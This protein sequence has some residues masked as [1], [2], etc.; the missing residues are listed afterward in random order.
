VL[1]NLSS[2]A[3]KFTAAGRVRLAVEALPGG[4]DR[5]RL[6]LSVTD[7]GSGID[8]GLRA[9]LF[10]PFVQGDTSAARRA[11][12][13]GLGLAI[14]R[15]IVDRMGGRI[16]VDSALGV[17]SRFTVE[18]ALPVAAEA[19][20]AT[21][22][23]APSGVEGSPRVLLVEDH[24]LSQEILTEMLEELGCEVTIAGTGVEAM[25]LA[26]AAAYDLILM[27]LQ[28]P[29]V[30][31]LTATRLIRLLPACRHTPIVALSANVFQE[32]RVRALEAGMNEHVAKP[33]TALDLAAVLK[34]WVP[35]A[36][37]G[38]AAR[39]TAADALLGQLR[40]SVADD[41]TRLR[42]RLADGDRAQAADI[43]HGA[44]GA[45]AL[46]GAAG[47]G[48][49]LAALERQLRRA[50]PDADAAVAADDQARLAAVALA[51]EALTGSLAQP[52]V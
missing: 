37:S 4:T 44:A 46:A 11:G 5:A 25:D 45:A 50:Q 2:N 23:L 48:Q 49:A 34:R 9:Q 32:D 51:L 14:C 6:R 30:D 21:Q 24:P 43:A 40:T 8:P 29:G 38:C 20:A 39:S 36:S 19:A 12:G 35:Q 33:V 10:D 7:S 28:L 27:D 17:G 22:A 13:T 18:L 42:A 47:L 15:R 1:I 26:G 31:G 52:A 3:I 41:M 16:E